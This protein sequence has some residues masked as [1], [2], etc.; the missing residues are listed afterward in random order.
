MFKSLK[1]SNK[2]VS[3]VEAGLKFKLNQLHPEPTYFSFSIVYDA[4][5]ELYIG[6]LFYKED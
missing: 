2:T 6:I 1:I 4:G 5:E 3:Q